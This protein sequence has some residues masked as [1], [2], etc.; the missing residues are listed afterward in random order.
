M[1]TRDGR[2][3]RISNTG[4]VRLAE[5]TGSIY[6]VL[7]DRRNVTWVVGEFGLRYVHAGRL[8]MPGVASSGDSAFAVF[9]D[10]EGSLWVGHRYA[11]LVRLTAG[12][13]TAISLDGDRSSVL[14]VLED[15][16]G[17]LW[18]GTAEGGLG[19]LDRD[20]LRTFGAA[21]DQMV[22]GVGPL[23]EDRH[24]R[25]WFGPQAGNAI[26]WFENGRV[27][28]L[29]LE[30]VAISMHED[31][32]GALWIGTLSHGLY[33][34]WKGQV[35]HWTTRDGLPSR[36]VRAIV[37]DGRGGLWLG[38]PRG[39]V[40]F[41]DRPTAV[42]TV[43]D[44]LR[45]DRVMAL[46]QEPA[47]PLWIGTSRGG[48]AR[49]DG[50]RFTSYGA[51]RG[52]C[53]EQVLAILDDGLGNLWMSSERGIFRVSKAQLNNVAAGVQATVACTSF[54]RDDGM[55]S[56]Q[57]SGGFQ[58]S[59]WRAR[60]GRLW[61][62]TVAGLV[63]VDPGAFDSGN[64]VPPP[65]HIESV[66][67]DGR[68]LALPFDTRL[69][70]GTKRLEFEYTALSLAA[71]EKVRF[72][73]RLSD[74]DQQ[75]VDA[76][77]QRRISY[78]GVPPGRYVFEV[79]AANNDGVWNEVGDR[80]EFRIER[81]FYQTAWFQG[82]ALMAAIAT[83][84]GL[85]VLRVSNL[86]LRS[87]VLA[88]RTHLSQEIHDHISQVM[89]GVVLQ[90]DAAT[91][92]LA[93]ESDASRPYIDRASRLARQGIEETRLILRT[94]REGSTRSLLE[95]VRLD[96]MIAENVAPLVE[97]TGVRLR[98]RLRGQ[99]RSLSSATR[100]EIFQVGREAV[101]NALRHGRASN[102]DIEVAFE[103]GGVRLTVNDDG[104]GFEVV[105]VADHGRVGLG[106]TGMAERVAAQHGTLDV[107][108]VPGRGT[109]IAAFFPW[110]AWAGEP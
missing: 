26:Q 60:D 33:R 73:Y 35:T 8:A 12:R 13:L 69:R 52:L 104:Q 28:S 41:S 59:G 11:G 10:R 17:A 72:R 61:F 25:V 23:L 86:R 6:G 64:A 83:A 65:V 75:W 93:P 109:R 9:E 95:E 88:E 63:A 90:L 68:E 5:Q 98:S 103:S 37:D 105:S 40:N 46:Y 76:N 4:A 31:P 2:L 43:A 84:S 57:A 16:Q 3:Y 39:L 66:L 19:R 45:S 62:P 107:R 96:Q 50:E 99:S 18:F 102:V 48:L 100:R 97:G 32:K 15:R 56:E 94:L 78:V 49:L 92:T 42:Y 82:L 110:P 74:V 1:G 71:P 54:G 70:A 21:K 20:G 22:R 51:D 77:S 30:G 53:D 47:G 106:L 27:S 14:S 87:A 79:V 38:T 89:T 101:T 36:A 80:W 29:P 85:H 24:G 34:I 108:S 67:A 91:Q 7:E 81:F 44:G 55:T 58:P